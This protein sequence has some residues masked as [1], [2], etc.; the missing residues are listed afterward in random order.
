MVSVLGLPWAV[1]FQ[2]VQQLGGSG[3]ALAAPEEA[4]APAPP[5]AGPDIDVKIDGGT[6]RHFISLDNPVILAAGGIALLL[7]IVLIAMAARGG[8]TTIIREK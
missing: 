7:V 3:V 8:G 5:A 6:E 1:G 2:P 4:P